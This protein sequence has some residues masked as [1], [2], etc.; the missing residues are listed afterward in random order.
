ML[1]YTSF[2]E[3]HPDYD[4]IFRT[5]L[6]PD[7]IYFNLVFEMTRNGRDAETHNTLIFI[8]WSNRAQKKHAGGPNICTMDFV[9]EIEELGAF[10]A[11][12]FDR[13]VDSSIINYFCNKTEAL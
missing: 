4:S 1:D 3:Q 13:D 11:R 9:E 8:D 6:I 10:F 12:K 2:I 7:E 5:A